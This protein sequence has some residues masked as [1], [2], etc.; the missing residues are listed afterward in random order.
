MVVFD[1]TILSLLLFPDASLG[2]LGSGDAVE[3]ARERVEGLVRE[4]EQAGEQVLIP[5]PVLCEV[6]VTEGADI[7]EVLDVLS[8]S[9][10][11]RIGDFDQRAA[12]ELAVR[13]REAIKKGDPREG[14]PIT[15]SA[16]KFDRQIVAIALVHGAST[17]YSDD[18]ALR[19]F[20]QNC[21]L[22]VKKVSELPVPESQRPLPF[23][24]T[25]GS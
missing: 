13:L 6:L 19:K 10:F 3:F 25:N 21:G 23:P 15:K 22:S 18:E 1:S 8:R 17:I 9:A 16:M 12:V 11:L 20:A 14:L 4:L 5:A 7:Q 24:E 2:Q